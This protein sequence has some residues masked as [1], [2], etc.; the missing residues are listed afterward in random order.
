MNFPVFIS[1]IAGTLAMTLFL[2]LICWLSKK[3]FH[4]IRILA[5]ILPFGKPVVTAGARKIV[6]LV[7][8]TLHYAIGVLFT[9]CFEKSIQ[10]H[11]MEFTL[12]NALLFGALA[13]LVGIIVWRIAFALHPKPPNINLHEY[14]VSIWLGHV[15][16][17]IAQFY[18]LM[19]L[20][21]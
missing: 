17:S 7:A 6:F 2:E 16:F 10:L 12:T 1:G 13:G 4:V 20:S 15:V 9:F 3:P 19:Y 11:L 14:L 8:V 5:Y 21:K 18:C